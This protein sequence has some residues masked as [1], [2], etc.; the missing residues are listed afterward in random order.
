MLAAGPFSVDVIPVGANTEYHFL[1][2][3][4]HFTSLI[5]DA[6]G[7]LILRP[8]PDKTD[9]NGWGT[10]WFLAPFL[11]GADPN[12]GVVDS[13]TPT[14]SGVDFSLHGSVARAGG[15]AYGTWVMQGSL[16]YDPET[17][18]VVGSGTLNIEL[19]G[20]LTAAG[21]DLNLDRISSNFLHDVPLQTGGV[22]DTGDMRGAFVSYS[23][24][25][26][27]KDFFW[28]PLAQPAHFPQ[29]LSNYLQVA[30][31]G[32]VNTVD[33]AKLGKGFQIAIARKPTLS[34]TYRCSP[35]PMI[36]GLIWDSSE[37]KNFAADNVGINHLILRGHSSAAKL[38]CTFSLDSTSVAERPTASR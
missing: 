23:P 3:G 19:D 7:R 11:A 5:V 21:A 13:V 25:G 37:G 6:E 32:A 8:H 16:S 14:P 2:D 4:F 34:V 29:D 17:Q 35:D 33:T 15:Q 28:L 12:S 9:P 1:R 26:D 36:A 10:S 22:G 27:P 24:S 38:G 31:S 20:S 18:R 30:V